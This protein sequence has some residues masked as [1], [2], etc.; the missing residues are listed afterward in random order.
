VRPASKLGRRHGFK[1]IFPGKM[2]LSGQSFTLSKAAYGACFPVY[3]R[4]FLVMIIGEAFI[5]A[6]QSLTCLNNSDNAYV[7][8]HYKP[9]QK[10]SFLALDGWFTNGGF[11]EW[12]GNGVTHQILR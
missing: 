12:T 2:P 5:R 11:F 6:K 10:R 4:V 8:C 1:L 3:N 9:F 7:I